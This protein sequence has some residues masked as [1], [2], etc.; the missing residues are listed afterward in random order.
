MYQ[1]FLIRMWSREINT[2]IH[3]KKLYELKITTK[4]T[5]EPTFDLSL[6]LLIMSLQKYLSNMGVIKLFFISNNIT[7]DLLII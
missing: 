4:D 7:K 1:I 2:N 3:C 5:F 6:I